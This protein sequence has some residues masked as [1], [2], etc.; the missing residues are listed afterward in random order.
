MNKDIQK[1]PAIPYVWSNS[2][3]L[4][5][6]EQITGAGFIKAIYFKKYVFKLMLK[7]GYSPLF[8]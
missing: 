2:Y 4:I 8:F 1:D 3:R 5:L 7:A 6:P